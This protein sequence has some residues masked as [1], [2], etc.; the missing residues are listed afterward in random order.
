M[1]NKGIDVDSI[2]GDDFSDLS[3]EDMAL[4]TGRGSNDAARS[5]CPL[6]FLLTSLFP[7]RCLLHRISMFPERARSIN[8]RLVRLGCRG[9][10]MP[11]H[12]FYGGVHESAA[13]QGFAVV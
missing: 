9:I 10:D 4:L 11:Q 1:S 13:V 12:P 6:R 2:V 5:H 7:L 3:P 8:R